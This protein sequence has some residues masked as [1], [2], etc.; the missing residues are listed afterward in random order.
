MRTKIILAGVYLFIAIC[1][2]LFLL[3]FLPGETFPT[4]S[5]LIQWDAKWYQQIKDQGY[6]FVPYRVCNMAFFPLFPLLWKTLAVSPLTISILNFIIFIAAFITMAVRN[7]MGNVEFLFILTIPMFVFCALP[8][9]ESTF[10]VFSLITLIGFDRDN[11]KLQFLGFLGA[12]LAR[13]ASIVAIP[14]LL[15]STILLKNSNKSNLQKAKQFVWNF[16]AIGLGIL[17]SAIMQGGQTGKWFY[18]LHI[19]QFWKRHWIIPQVPFTTYAPDKMLGIDALG[20]IVGTVCFC[21]CCAWIYRYLKK[22]GS[23]SVTQSV[24]F[25]CFYITGLALL[26]VFFTFQRNGGTSIW[27]IGRH[28]L[29]SPF[30]IYFL[31]WWIRDLKET[32]KIGW[33]LILAITCVLPISGI[34]RY[35]QHIIFILSS[36]LGVII[37][38][39]FPKYNLTLIILCFIN[40]FFQ[41]ETFNR[42]LNGGWIG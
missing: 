38:K 23:Y 26:D 35:P 3:R 20:L 6:V 32:N 12:S 41:L 19:Q 10:F 24:I 33:I 42:Y 4:D 27:S 21:F 25:S 30:F 18:F 5:N 37:L 40:L 28:V 13:S 11:T 17:F 7:K 34:F 31:L 29:C 14:A 8:Y 22:D 15:I 9:S 16:V 2:Y 39:Y 36:L 1:F